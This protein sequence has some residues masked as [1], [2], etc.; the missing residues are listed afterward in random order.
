MDKNEITS[1]INCTNLVFCLAFVL[2]D[3]DFDQMQMGKSVVHEAG[4]NLQ[5]PMFEEENKS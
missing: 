3:F 4:Q 1:F 2:V 5:S